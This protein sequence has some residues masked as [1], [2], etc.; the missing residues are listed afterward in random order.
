MRLKTFPVLKRTGIVVGLLAY[1]V[2]FNHLFQM[3]LAENRLRFNPWVVKSAGITMGRPGIS[4]ELVSP[5]LEAM[6]E[7]PGS[8]LPPNGTK[9]NFILKKPDEL[10]FIVWD[11]S[12]ALI[13]KLE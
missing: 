7:I 1:F 10:P 2:L 3:A 4:L 13:F 6:H 11:A 12:Q 8:K 9:G 5:P